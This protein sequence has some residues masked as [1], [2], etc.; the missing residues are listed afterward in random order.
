MQYESILRLHVL[1]H[2]GHRKL[3]SL[4]KLDLEEWIA[5][6]HKAG[7]SGSTIRAAT[8]LAKLILTSAVDYGLIQTNPM[9]GIKMPNASSKIKPVLTVEQVEKLLAAFDAHYR[10]VVLVLAYGGFRPHE[11]FALRRRHLDDFGRLTVELGL[12]E[13]RGKLVE[14]DTKTHKSRLVT[15]PAT[16]LVVLREHMAANPD[17]GPEAP[18]FVTPSGTESQADEL[19][20]RP[21]ED[22]QGES[23]ASRVGNPVHPASH[24]GEFVG[25]PGDTSEHGG[26]DA[27]K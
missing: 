16:V 7:K 26:Q 3:R 9:A 19:P 6:L 24:D 4:R 17:A 12:V 23:R 1:P 5:S 21:L 8:V 14:G 2:L 25:E 27:R 11:A 22:R 15:L 13:V 18:I 20:Q 10:A